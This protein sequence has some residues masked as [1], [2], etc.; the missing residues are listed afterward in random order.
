MA[1]ILRPID[2][3]IEAGKF[4]PQRELLPPESAEVNLAVAGY[5]SVR[6]DLGAR[7]EHGPLLAQLADGTYVETAYSIRQFED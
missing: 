5:V 2:L 1:E 4:I 7:N 6:L 3:E